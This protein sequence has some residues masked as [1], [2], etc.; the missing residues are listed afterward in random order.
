MASAMTFK[1]LLVDAGARRAVP[2]LATP[3]HFDSGHAGLGARK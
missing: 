3:P 1:N 2:L